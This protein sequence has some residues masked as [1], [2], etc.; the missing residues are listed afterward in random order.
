MRI[1]RPKVHGMWNLHSCLSNRSL[2]FFVNLA[3]AS[4]VW[5]SRG[6][7]TYAATSTALGAFA[8]WRIAQNMPTV[9]IHLGRVSEVGYV[10]ERKELEEALTKD[11]ATVAISEREVHGLIMTAIE[12]R[13]SGPEIYAGLSLAWAKTHPAWLLDPKLSHFRTPIIQ[14]GKDRSSVAGP[15]SL[16]ML[17]KKADSIAAA[18]QI[19]VSGLTQKLCSLLMLQEDDIDA[20]QPLKAQG[21][22][23][24]V[25][26]ELR[27][28]I[29]KELEVGINLV[30]IM[31]AS[32]VGGLAKMIGRRSRLVDWKELEKVG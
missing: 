19:I 1:M 26:V 24:L 3:S 9:T 25:M 31:D 13:S 21:L 20:S 5:G 27:N 7:S 8:R 14:D 12:G 29:S 2:D 30:E 22:D 32:S 10:A 23:S 11:S 28:W 17:L 4:G 18:N 15:T 6:L 16:P